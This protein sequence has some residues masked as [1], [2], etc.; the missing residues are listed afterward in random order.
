[1]IKSKK[2]KHFLIAMI[3]ITLSVLFCIFAVPPIY[4]AQHDF[5]SKRAVIRRFKKDYGIDIR[6]Y[7]N[8]LYYDH[9]VTLDGPNY[10]GLFA[11]TIESS[12]FFN[13]ISETNPTYK[14]H[15]SEKEPNAA[16]ARL[17]ASYVYRWNNDEYNDLLKGEFYWIDQAEYEHSSICFGYTLIFLET[18]FVLYKNDC[19]I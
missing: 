3:C 14:W 15:Y 2:L 19:G 7:A 9:G 10:F 18:N 1:M 13:I 16:E 6:S 17:T 8:I 5:F 4:V 12:E 11:L